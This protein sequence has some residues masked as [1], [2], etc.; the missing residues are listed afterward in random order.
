[1]AA[2]MVI[3][4]RMLTGA[5]KRFCCLRLVRFQFYRRNVDEKREKNEKRE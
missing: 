2:E 5:R 3:V 4:M 1:M